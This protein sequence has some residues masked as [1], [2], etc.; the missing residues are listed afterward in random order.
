MPAFRVEQGPR[1]LV[2]TL[3]DGR[4]FTVYDRVHEGGRWITAANVRATHRVFVGTD[5]KNY[6]YPLSRGDRGLNATDLARQL[7]TLV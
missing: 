3:D 1:R 2:L 4:D 5:G 7:M 6:R